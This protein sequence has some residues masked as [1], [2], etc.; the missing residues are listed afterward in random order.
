MLR[1]TKVVPRDC[2]VLEHE[3]GGGFFVE[4][5]K[6]TTYKRETEQ[7]A[8]R[9][10][11]WKIG[12][13]TLF[14]EDGILRDELLKSFACQAAE[15]RNSGIDSV[16]I[17]SGAVAMGR[18]RSPEIMDRK[19][20]SVIGQPLLSTVWNNAF[21]PVPVAQLLLTQEALCSE[22]Q[23]REQIAGAL[24]NGVVPVINC[25]DPDANNDVTGLHVA[26]AIQA[27]Q[28]A[29]LTTT[30]GVLSNGKSIPRI[31]K[32]FDISSVIQDGTSSGGTGGMGPK[33]H[34]ASSFA[35]TGGLAV[36]AHGH[37]KDVLRRIALGESFN[38]T[39]FEQI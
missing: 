24:E 10:I 3:Q 11:V 38:G 12:T 16:F 9:R 37:E 7:S 32:E 35:Q 34:A 39:R 22:N 6:Q 27:E 19:L 2:L 14:R 18:L 31:T 5:F 30:H 26:K 15:L 28:L 4:I 23:L 1:R 17:S 8:R 33:C 20:L 29:L 21:Y 36:I 25:I 13:S